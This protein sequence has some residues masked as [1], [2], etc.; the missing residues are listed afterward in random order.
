MV[1]S[2]G[3]GLFPFGGSVVMGMLHDVSHFS[4]V[5]FSLVARLVSLRVHCIAAACRGTPRH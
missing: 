2:T 5:L 4:L 1:C 3:Y